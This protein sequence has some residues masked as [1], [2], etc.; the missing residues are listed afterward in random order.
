MLKYKKPFINI[1]FVMIE[2][3]ILSALIYRIQRGM[4]TTDESF[5]ASVGYRIAKGNIPIKEMWEMQQTSYILLYPFF[6]IYTLIKGSEG[7]QLA[8]RFFNLVLSIF[9]ALPLAIFLKKLTSTKFSCLLI[10][11]YAVYAPFS[12][13]TL[14]YNNMLFHFG[15]LTVG[16]LL[17]GYMEDNHI[18]FF[19]SGSSI[20]LMAFCYPTQ[21]ITCCLLSIFLPVFLFMLKAT[22]KKGKYLA[23]LCGGIQIAIIIITLLF[24]LCGFHGLQTGIHGMLSDA[25]YGSAKSISPLLFWEIIKYY[26]MPLQWFPLLIFILCTILLLIFPAN[27]LYGLIAMAVFPGICY[28][29]SWNFDFYATNTMGHIMQLCSYA[30][31]IM[32]CCKECRQNKYVHAILWLQYVPCFLIYTVVSLSSAGSYM[33]ANNCLIIAALAGMEAWLLTIASFKHLYKYTLLKVSFPLL[34]S[35]CLLLA[36]YKVVYRDSPIEFLTSKMESGPFKGIYTTESWNEY[37]TNTYELLQKMQEKEKT[38]CILYRANFAYLMLDQM[39]PCTPATW[40]IYDSINNEQTFLYFFENVNVPDII[41]IV[42]PPEPYERNALPSTFDYCSEFTPLLTKYISENY[43]LVEVVEQEACA[44][45][46]KYYAKNT[47]DK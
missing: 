3:L 42:D 28:Y 22:D 34:L 47:E 41:F 40:G 44:T 38:V 14:G 32:L 17:M 36:F 24:L 43:T 6:K 27:K 11:C 8:M 5:Y 4:E 2:L 25:A 20:A 26:F 7:I 33:Q 21:I 35:G 13:Y 15:V 10:T 39:I 30:F 31:P 12:L 23:F 1:S 29:F 37:Y 9:A 46:R 18:Y 19:L 45:V 16:F